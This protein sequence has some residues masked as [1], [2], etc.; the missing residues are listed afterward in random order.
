MQT[1]QSFVDYEK[2]LS[3]LKRLALA[4]VF[5]LCVLS[6][7][8]GWIL[9]RKALKGIE[10]VTVI[11]DRIARGD[12]HL[13]VRLEK[14]SLEVQKLADTF[15]GML[16]R[17]QALI[18]GLREVTDN[19]AHDLRSP[20]ARIRG[21]AELTIVGNGSP[22]DYR[23]MA[24]STVEECDNLIDMINTMLDITEVEAG[25]GRFERE[26]VSVNALVLEACELFEPIAKEKDIALTAVLP[27]NTLTIHGDRHKLQ[28]VITNLIENGIKYNRP[29]G[30]VTVHAA[31]EDGWV[32]IKVEDTGC[33]I[34]AADIPRIFDRFYRCDSSRSE[35]GLGLGLS[36]A[37][38]I[39]R[40]AG[41]D[42]AVS[43]VVNAGSRFTVRLPV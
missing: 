32:Q 8:V 38:A 17:I 43:S 37:K 26:T 25:I 15:N 39:A 21:K 27:E 9:S 35:P 22:A 19:I 30:S 11:A 12:Y 42:I 7:L 18:K 13:R 2:L 3:F 34:P 1:G 24:A 36:L 4:V 20:L 33:G 16:D 28:R 23:D 29:G 14:S 5:P 6:T 41:G 10:E 40:A 31:V